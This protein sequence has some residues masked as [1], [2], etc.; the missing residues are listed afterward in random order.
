M[1]T[2]GNNRKWNPQRGEKKRTRRHFDFRQKQERPRPDAVM[3]ACVAMLRPKEP[4]RLY[5]VAGMRGHIPRYY[6]HQ[7]LIVAAMTHVAGRSRFELMEELPL[8]EHTIHNRQVQWRRHFP[9]FMQDEWLL[10]IG[11]AAFMYEKSESFFWNHRQRWATS[12]RWLPF[13]LRLTKD[14]TE[15]TN[16]DLKWTT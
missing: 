13:V 1:E 7:I 11:E 6:W 4:D 3:A 2:A 14:T 16:L 8:T 15:W 9:K 5:I 10:M 12:I